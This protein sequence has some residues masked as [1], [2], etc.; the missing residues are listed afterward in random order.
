MTLI[1]ERGIRAP[2]PLAAVLLALAVA[3]ALA[4]PAP[5]AVAASPT[6]AFYPPAAKAAGVG[7]AATL[8]CERRAMGALVHCALQG[9]SPPGYGFG[10]AALAIAA[11]TRDD[12]VRPIADEQRDPQLYSFRFTPAPLAITPDALGPGGLDESPQ[13]RRIPDAN[14]FAAVFPDEMARQGVSGRVVL[15]C[16]AEADGQL[17]ACRVVQEAPPAVGFGPAAIKVSRLFR[18]KTQTCHN[19]IK[20]I[21]VTIPIDFMAAR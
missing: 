16:A 7:G 21:V 4:D 11:A 13:W 14:D 17:S 20:G 8:R 19:S 10:K 2:A 1:D 3:P 18:L 5:P 12:C 9:E 6:L 15:N